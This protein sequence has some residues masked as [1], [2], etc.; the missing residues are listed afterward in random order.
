MAFPI[1][2]S[3]YNMF[4]MLSM[5]QKSIRRGDYEHAGF[6][7]NQ[8]RGTFRKAMWNR[9]LVISAEDCFGVITK[10]LV[11]VRQMDDSKA[12]DQNISNIV[13]LMCR[14]RKS[15]DACYFACNFVL[16]SRCP[17]KL[18]P[19]E[20]EIADLYRRTNGSGEGGGIND[21]F[22]N[23][24]F[25]QISIFETDQRTES[26]MDGV[27]EKDREKATAGVW[28][29]IALDHRDMDMIGYEIDA[30]RRTDR[31]F[32]WRVLEDYACRK[33]KVISE[34]V[35]LH[36]AD[37]IVNQRKKYPDKDEIFV[38]KAAVILCYSKDDSV[39]SVLS[40]D[41]VCLDHC[42]NWDAFR[43]K[44]MGSCTLGNGSIPEWVYDC[45]TL[46]GRKMGKTD[47]DMTVDEQA[48]LYPL[49]K[50]YFDDASWIYTYEQ[51]FRNGNITESGI[52]P[53]R[54]YAKTH[55]ANPVQFIPYE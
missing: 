21:G 34:I 35:A 33:T 28:M 15:R 1:T 23:F 11:R 3:G 52:R 10:E 17:R 30:L 26:P 37:N 48:A 27:P 7:A 47:W 18:E 32:L 41:I 9:L 4:D 8:L 51:D 39:D 12:D 14:A 43:I 6:A 45:H 31:E 55:L 24:G 42:I 13:A 22:D 20:E 19:S 25:A 54:E 36:E 29:Q 40:S 50:T 53:I 16:D 38:S 46:R 49:R 44:R 2:E 5:I